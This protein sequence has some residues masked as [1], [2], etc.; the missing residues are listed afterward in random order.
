ML[1]LLLLLMLLLHPPLLEVGRR[2]YCDGTGRARGEAAAPI[3][4]DVPVRSCAAATA[5]ALMSLV[6]S[7][8]GFIDG[9]IMLAETR[10]Q[11]PSTPPPLLLLL[12]PDGGGGAA[13]AAALL[14]GGRPP[15]TA[16]HPRR[17]RTRAALS[18]CQFACA[19]I[20]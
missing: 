17:L 12:P 18:A 1:L 10:D 15:T 16:A 19:S 6:R 11:S 4:E 8:T 20:P 9:W 7:L 5:A 13:A 14:G 2:G 3:P